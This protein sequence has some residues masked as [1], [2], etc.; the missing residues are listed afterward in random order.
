ML[1]AKT[2]ADD[3]TRKSVLWSQA[4]V[5]PEYR[6]KRLAA[7]LYEERLEWSQSHPQYD[8]A[9][10]FIHEDNKRS[11]DLHEKNGA[12]IFKREPMNWPGRPKATWYWYEKKLTA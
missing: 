4:Y 2:W 6:G 1:T 10:F 3:P 12:H 7:Q 8:R 5:K 9:V 11:Q